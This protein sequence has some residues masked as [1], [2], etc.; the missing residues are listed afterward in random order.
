MSLTPQNKITIDNYSQSQ[1]ASELHFTIS[2]HYHLYWIFLAIT[3][4]SLPQITEL[5]ITITLI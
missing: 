5:F 4:Y 2:L 1:M 3:H